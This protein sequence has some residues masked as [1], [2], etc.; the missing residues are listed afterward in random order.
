[1]KTVVV[2]G[3]G[4][5][6]PL[7][8]LL[9]DPALVLAADACPAHLHR[10]RFELAALRCLSHADFLRIDRPGRSR[11][12]LYPRV[13]WMLP[14]SAAAWWD[15]RLAAPEPAGFHA[16]VGAAE[17]DFLKVRADRLQVLERPLHALL[18]GLPDGF[19]DRVILA[20]ECGGAD[21]AGEVERVLKAEKV[22]RSASAA[23]QGR[24]AE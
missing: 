8:T 19:A 5:A 9:D 13:R 24:P 2:V 7:W 15:V 18:A 11:E 10:V 1:M 14:A 3:I 17:F 12:R 4:E 6:D 22:F 16:P 20:P 23:L 21:P